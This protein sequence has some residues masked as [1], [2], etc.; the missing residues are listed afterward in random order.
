MNLWTLP[1]E[2]VLG[3]Q[4]FAIRWQWQDALAVLKLLDEPRES[5]V[6]WLRA[7]E[8][9]YVSPVPTPLLGEAMRWMEDFLTAGQAYGGGLKLLDWQ[10]DAMEILSDINRVAGTEVRQTS[11]HWWTFLGWFHAIGEG[12][13]SELVSLRRKLATG[14]KLT[15]EEQS[16]YR[17]NRAKVRLQ[18]A[19]DPEKQRL[20]QL[21]GGGK[22]GR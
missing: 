10:Q 6:C 1:R 4:H 21:L 13:L 20:E 18:T 17:Q 22:N 15:E 9:F 12:R 11:A 16:F 7:V 5:W 3:G 19:P 14:Q 8:R 2:A